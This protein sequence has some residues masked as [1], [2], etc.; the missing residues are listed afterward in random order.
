MQTSNVLASN[1]DNMSI[2]ILPSITLLF[3]LNIL[4]VTYPQEMSELLSNKT[5][6]SRLLALVNFNTIPIDLRMV[7]VTMASRWCI[8]LDSCPLAKSNMSLLVDSFYYNTGNLPSYKF[9]TKLPKDTQLQA[10]WKYPPMTPVAG[11][12][13]YFYIPAKA[14][15]RSTRASKTTQLHPAKPRNAE[16]S[17]EHIETSAQKLLSLS[18]ILT[19]NLGMARSNNNPQT[20]NMVKDIV[21]QINTEL[22]TVLKHTCT[23]NTVSTKLH[24]AAN[25][26]KRSLALYNSTIECQEDWANGRNKFGLARAPKQSKYTRTADS[27]V[28]GSKANSSGFSLGSTV[29]Q[30]ESSKPTML[31]TTGSSTPRQVSNSSSDYSNSNR[32]RQPGLVHM[33]EKA[34]GKMPAQL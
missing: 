1:L 24:E 20:D 15:V 28:L 10:N 3:V 9:L 22:S 5:N 4:V 14:A 11:D 18:E 16:Y 34:K 31:R 23:L 33:S 19:V 21:E 27:P 7:V 12:M 13:S 2:D 6:A 17:L 26:A 29:C 30:G 8:L 25:K 32:G